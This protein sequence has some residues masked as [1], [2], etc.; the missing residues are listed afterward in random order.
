M[1]QCT[2]LLE[3]IFWLPQIYT[4]CIIGRSIN[5]HH[6]KIRPMRPRVNCVLKTCQQYIS[7]ADGLQQI[8]GSVCTHVT[9]LTADSGKSNEVSS[10]QHLNSLKLAWFIIGRRNTKS[11]NIKI[12]QNKKYVNACSHT[13]LRVHAHICAH[14]HVHYLHKLLLFKCSVA[15]ILKMLKIICMLLL[16]CC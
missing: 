11:V 9:L 1:W 10:C 4:S 13:G 14:K 6:C 16:F 12:W 7:N 2:T 15:C 8:C 3:V 5:L